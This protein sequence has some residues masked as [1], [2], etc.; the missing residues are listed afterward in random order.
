MSHYRPTAAELARRIKVNT[1]PITS[2]GVPGVNGNAQIG[3]YGWWVGDQGVK[4]PI[5]MLT[6]AAQE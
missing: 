6:G 5:I 1:L 2:P 3:R 4:A